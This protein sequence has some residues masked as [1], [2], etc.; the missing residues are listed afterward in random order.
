MVGP[1]T[2]DCNGDASTSIPELDSYDYDFLVIGGGSGG[3]S[4]SKRAAM[5]GAKTAVLDYVC[6]SPIGSSWGLG[7]TCVNVGNIRCGSA[8][9]PRAIVSWIESA[10]PS[11]GILPLASVSVLY[12]LL[13]ILAGCIPKKLMHQSA[14]FGQAAK[15]MPHFGWELKEGELKH[16]WQTMVS[17]IQDYIKSLNWGYRVALQVR[18]NRIVFA[19][20]LFLSRSY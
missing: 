17:N 5:L 8:A 12:G 1:S 11:T 3:L 20:C 15:D 16:N 10:L 9:I 4:A 6:P 18:G 2:T 13:L 14:L 19:V 7:G